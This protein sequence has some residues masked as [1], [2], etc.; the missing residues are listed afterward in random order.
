[1]EIDTAM[2]Q[3]KLYTIFFLSII[4]WMS[5]KT[6][7][8][9]ASQTKI[10]LPKSY[11]EITDSVNSAN[12]KWKDFFTDKDLVALIDTALKN[13]LDILMTLQKIEVARND[14]RLSKGAMLPT[15]NANFAYLQR[16]FGYYTMDDAGNRVTEIRPGEIVPTHLPDYFVGLQANWEIDIWGKLRNKKKAAFTRYLGS[17]EAVN[18]VRTNLIAEISN[19]YYELL[20]LDVE[21]DIIDE[22]I[23][24]QKNML[25]IFEIQKQSGVTNELAIKQFEAQV[26]NS[27]NLKFELLQKINENEN[28]L[29]FLLG[30]FPQPIVRNKSN[31]NAQTP[32]LVKAGVPSQLLQNR[33][34]IKQS[35]YELLASNLNVKA[36]KAAF[37]PSF[38]ITGTAGFQSFNTSFLFT[39]PQSLA[40]NLLGSLTT[41]LI[42][43]SAIKAQFKNAKANQVEAMYKYQK[44]VL[45]AYVEVSNELSNIR[46]LENIYSLKTEEVSTLDS[47]ISIATDLFKSGRATYFEVL[48]TQRSALESK[49]DLVTAKKRQYISTVNIYKALGGGW[50]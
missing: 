19:T 20:A 5:C 38:M 24:I 34:D 15:V 9:D 50:R 14:L 11:S 23:N 36:A 13:N 31:F 48:M 1:M 12:I 45:N 3:F 44:T 22:T 27:R 39:T 28:K 30:R 29:N 40:Y 26:L 49:L 35:E 46:N 8:S 4:L 43:R 2:N 25:E 37:Y 18:L 21:L 32:M 16:K 10:S 17:T 47:S 41:P 6:T 42:N 33:P 7:Q